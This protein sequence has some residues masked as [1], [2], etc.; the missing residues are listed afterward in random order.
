M[1]EVFLARQCGSQHLVAIKLAVPHPRSSDREQALR[2][3]REVRLVKDLSHPNLVSVLEH[4][5]A[6]GRHYFVMEYVAGGNLRQLLQPGQPL[7]PRQALNMLGEIVRALMYLAERGIVHRDLKPENVL[8][9]ADGHVKVSDFGLSTPVAEVGLVTA[10]AQWLGTVDYM[11]PEQRARLPLDARAD[12]F[13]LA[14]I[15]YE[16]LTGRRPLGNF[17]HPSQLNPRLGPAV[18]RVL[19]RALQEDAD[20][21]YPSV[22][23]F[24]EALGQALQDPP[25]GRRERKRAAAVVLA[26][27]LLV[28]AG[29]TLFAYVGGDHPEDQAPAPAEGDGKLSPVEEDWE[30][31][32]HPPRLR[33]EVVPWSPEVAQLVR[34]AQKQEARHERQQAI[35]TYS[36]AIRLAPEDPRLL[37]L[38]AHSLLLQHA[39]REALADLDQALLLDPELG[40]AYTGRGAIFVQQGEHK[41]ALADLNR[42]IALNP[43]DA[44]AHAHRGRAY[45][46]LGMSDPARRDLDRAIELDRSCGLAYHFRG[47]LAQSHEQYEQARADLETSARLTPDNPFAFTALAWLLATCKDTTQRDG[48]LARKHGQEA[49]RLSQWKE[50]NALRAYAAAHAESGDLVSAVHWCD[51]ALRAAPP[52]SQPTLRKQR[53]EYAQRLPVPLGVVPR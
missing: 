40:E 48:P 20:D 19:G 12:Q 4:G 11:A 2:H 25:L 34:V 5:S 35:R 21:R 10:S 33:R 46:S 47:L 14:V 42:A 23:A 32:A 8:V 1:G 43:R 16:M 27:A 53:A 3:E 37:V 51:A 17:K 29:L 15:A 41:N 26:L 31:L 36:E 44:L 45:R 39:S 30:L 6:G 28:G 22:R 7:E 24:D 38:R 9:D 49:C 13:S 52:I 18:D 50:W